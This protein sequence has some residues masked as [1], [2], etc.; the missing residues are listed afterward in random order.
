M[1]QEQRCSRIANRAAG[2]DQQ[3]QSPQERRGS[4]N[5]QHETTLPN[6]LAVNDDVE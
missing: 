2:L 1:S 5:E 6:R 4:D 3:N